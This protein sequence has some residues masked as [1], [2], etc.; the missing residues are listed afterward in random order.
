MQVHPG[1]LDRTGALGRTSSRTRR[2]ALPRPISVRASPGPENSHDNRLSPWRNDPVCDPPGE[3]IFLRDDEDGR[4]WSATPLPAGGGQPYTVRHGQGYSTFEHTRN[5]IASRLRLFVPH[6]EQR[7]GF[8][9]RRAEQV[10]ARAAAVGDALRRVDARRASLPHPPPR[11]H[12]P[13]AGH[14]C[15]PGDERL[16]GSVRRSRGLRRSARRLAG[17]EACRRGAHHH[18][19]SQRVHRAQRLAR[20]TRGAFTACGCR[21]AS[22]RGSIPAAPSS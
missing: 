20:L 12:Q 2:S 15:G 22:A 19:R 7:Q 10:V 18:R 16:S 5:D 3:A 21:I 1:R 14:R 9:A 13:R 6:G 17:A 8:R 11:R 4:V